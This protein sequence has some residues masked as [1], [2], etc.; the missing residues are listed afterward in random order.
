MTDIWNP[1]Q[2]NGDKPSTPRLPLDEDELQ[3]FARYVQKH[4]P[5]VYANALLDLFA[6]GYE[7]KVPTPAKARKVSQ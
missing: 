6:P 5:A 4:A 3:H 1:P 2:L 7:A